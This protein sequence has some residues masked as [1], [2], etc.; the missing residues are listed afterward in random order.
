MAGGVTKKELL[1]HSL[2]GWNLPSFEKNIIAPFPQ[3][4]SKVKQLFKG[5]TT[6][7]EN[8]IVNV[9]PLNNAVADMKL[10]RIRSIVN[11]GFNV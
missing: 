9:Q 8:N 1:F 6:L 10:P 3:E 5:R 4:L 2:L 11:H 7:A